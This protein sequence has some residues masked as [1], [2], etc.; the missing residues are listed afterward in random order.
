MP[1]KGLS[2]QTRLTRLGKIHLG[3]KIEPEGR[4]S[5]PRP[6]D[7]FVCPPEVQEVFG[8]QPKTLSIT[9]PTEDPEQWASAFYR[10]YS[11]YQGLV[12]RGD[13]DSASRLVDLD[14]VVS[15]DGELPEDMHPRAWPVANRESTKTRWTD[16]I[17]PPDT[18][19]EY[20]RK[21]CRPT[22]NLQFML[23]DVTGLGVYQIDTSS[24][25]SMRN[26]LSGIQLIKGLCS[27][28][29]LIPLTLSLVPREV[30]PEGQ[31]KKII[32]ILQL[33]APY[34]LADLFKYAALPPGQAMLPAPDTEPPEDLFPDVEPS[35]PPVEATID[36]FFQKPDDTSQRKAA[37][38]GVQ[39]AVSSKIVTRLQVVK[40]L[41]ENHDIVMAEE[42]L[43]QKLAK[44]DPPRS[45]STNIL[46]RLHDG[47][48]QLQLR[49]ETPAG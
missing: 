6:T 25:N 7:Y 8:D 43:E 48:S 35:Q 17:C 4:A 2:E 14:K 29:S 10:A 26:I 40:W 5:Y 31:G 33:T 19:P 44:E 32:H 3:I 41:R 1:I 24:W 13:G 21:A 34:K 27:R 38:K 30:Q 49:M 42:L 16:I 12:C 15:G 9:F 23:P 18:C 28:I 45:L 37:W 47:L 46:T 36:S 22:M 39:D 11:S 20:G